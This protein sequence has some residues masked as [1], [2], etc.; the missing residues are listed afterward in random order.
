MP[1]YGRGRERNAF[2]SVVVPVIPVAIASS[3]YPLT[4]LY[5]YLT[6]SYI[7]CMSG[8]L[9]AGPPP[10]SQQ[11]QQQSEEPALIGG[12]FSKL[13]SGLASVGAA[14]TGEG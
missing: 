4:H 8:N 7:H 6:M 2:D 1:T 13:K 10:M 14:I 5:V 3:L 11:Q 12:F 9:P